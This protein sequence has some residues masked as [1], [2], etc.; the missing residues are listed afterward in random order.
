MSGR[1]RRHTSTTSRTCASP[2]GG[3]ETGGLELAAEERYRDGP[4]AVELAGEPLGLQPPQALE[5]H[6]LDVR[7]VVA[8]VR[9]HAFVLRS[10]I[11]SL[12]RGGAA[13]SGMSASG[14]SSTSI[15]IKTVDFSRSA[16]ARASASGSAGARTVPARRRA[17]SYRAPR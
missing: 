2:S 13:A 15:W 11:A 16:S 7:V 5:R 17:R 6:R 8:T 1:I 14:T 10:T 12:N 9:V 3:P 4:Y